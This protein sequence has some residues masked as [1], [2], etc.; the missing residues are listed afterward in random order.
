MLM[1]ESLQYQSLIEFISDLRSPETFHKYEEL[2][3]EKASSDHYE[4]D[5]TRKKKRKK[6][7]DET[8]DEDE[9]AQNTGGDHFRVN[10]FYP[11]LDNL[12]SELKRRSS[13]YEQFTKQFAALTNI[14]ELSSTELREKANILIKAYP[15]D[16]EDSF[17]EECVHFQGHLRASWGS[18]LTLSQISQKFYSDDLSS[19]YPNIE[20]AIR[21]FLCTPATN[22]TAER[23]F[24]CL[25]RVKNYL[26]SR[27][28]ED[29]L[30]ALAILAIE[31]DLLQGIDY[32][33][34]IDRFARQQTRRKLF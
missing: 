9:P 8:N 6:P 28:V 1:F 3:R 10:T 31:S 5:V 34:I 22:C 14:T 32:D 2:A 11:I 18:K 30:N 7:F 13:A 19:I 25:K 33:E 24:S 26:R 20:V 4:I 23:S 15:D 29:R 16:I 17:E 12:Q 27:M 21:I